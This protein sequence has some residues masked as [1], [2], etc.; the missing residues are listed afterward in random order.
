MRIAIIGQPVRSELQ[1]ALARHWKETLGAELSL[2]GGSEKGLETYRALAPDLFDRFVVAPSPYF[3]D[4]PEDGVEVPDDETIVTR[5]LDYEERFGVPLNWL[6]TVDR[7]HGLGYS[8]GGFYFPRSYGEAKVSQIDVLRGYLAFFEF[9]DR[10]L[11][12]QKFDV[13]INGYNFEYFP[14]LANDTPMRT[15]T[16]ARN[17]NFYFWSHSCFG[18]LDGLDSAYL[19][20]SA[21]AVDLPDTAAELK[22]APVLNR[23]Q[24]DA[25]RR[26]GRVISLLPRIY[27]ILRNWALRQIGPDV[28][29]RYKLS[30]EL[31]YA[32]TEWWSMRRLRRSGM[33]TAAELAGRKYLFYALQVEPE[34]NFQGFSPEYFSLSG[35]SGLLC[36]PGTIEKQPMSSS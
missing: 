7:V 19:G 9:W 12:A 33:P 30:S 17:G 4:A 2:Y 20:T 36:V 15:L 28:K 27:R 18:E 3:A 11:V 32:F 34:Q 21:D 29:K 22:D 1:I 14:C 25:L 31:R 8:P 23:K 24:L 10:E 26:R 13:L 6:M 16:S 5:A 35:P